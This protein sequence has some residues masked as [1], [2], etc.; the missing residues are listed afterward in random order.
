MIK[1]C[2]AKL[3]FA[4]A[5]GF[6]TIGIAVTALADNGRSVIRTR[7]MPL[8]FEYVIGQPMRLRA[9]LV[10]TG[11]QS[12]IYS[13]YAG[14]AAYNGRVLVR[15]PEG[16]AVP[17]VGSWSSDQE[18][19]GAKSLSLRPA[20][21]VPI[22]T[23]DLSTAYHIDRPG[24][25]T[26]RLGENQFMPASSP[27]ELLV[28]P[29]QLSEADEIVGRFL[30]EFKR[31]WTLIKELPSENTSSLLRSPHAIVRVTVVKGRPSMGAS[32]AVVI[33][34]MRQAV[35]LTRDDRSLQ[36]APIEYFGRNPWGV[37]YA[38]DIVDERAQAQGLLSRVRRKI[39]RAL[40]I[41]ERP[42][43]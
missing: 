10:N 39:V 18:E 12:A 38:A 19:A 29:G 15:G 30:R 37:V 4:M 5:I 17:Y 13:P 6:A 28:K 7:L 22:F 24:P 27:V 1:Y 36:N 43:P 33:W 11:S 16:A 34:Q 32:R 9:E 31:E 3:G 2:A 40:E 35:D 26:V 23:I 14:Y 42:E 20:E 25:Y 21:A 8:E 41:D